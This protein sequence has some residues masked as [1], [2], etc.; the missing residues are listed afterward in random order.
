[1]NVEPPDVI[2]INAHLLLH[3]GNLQAYGLSVE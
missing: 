2:R 1:M 3:D